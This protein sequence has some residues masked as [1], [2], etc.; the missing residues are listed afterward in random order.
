MAAQI[1][2]TD[3]LLNKYINILSKSE[4]F[5]R[6]IFDEKWYGAEAVRIFM[7]SNF[8]TNSSS[9]RTSKNWS[10][11]NTSRKSE[12]AEQL[13]KRRVENVK[14]KSV[15]NGRRR[16]KGGERKER[17]WRGRKPRERFGVV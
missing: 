10:D 17:G 12:R 7:Q 8:L 1:V 4:E 15:S 5:S 6:L 11:K 9:I 13:R 2:E 16:C 3:A 14:N